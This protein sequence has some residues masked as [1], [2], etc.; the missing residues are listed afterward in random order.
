YERASSSSASARSRS[1]LRR[2][3]SASNGRGSIVKSRSP[4]ATRPPSS[5]CTDSTKPPTRA[6][7]SR[8]LAA[9]RRPLKSAQSR[10]CRTVTSDAVTAAGG[11]ADG[12]CSASPLAQP[13][14][15]AA[16]S[17]DGT[18]VATGCV[19]IGNPLF[20]LGVR[21]R[22]QQQQKLGGLYGRFGKPYLDSV[23]RSGGLLL[24]YRLVT[25]QVN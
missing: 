19:L 12:D 23:A 9:S 2:A 13:A 18:R 3:T 21:I 16:A 24:L 25:S 11:G 22:S 8:W 4:R 1:A 20:V 14:S 7:T 17:N 10:S 5:K 15:T 6:C